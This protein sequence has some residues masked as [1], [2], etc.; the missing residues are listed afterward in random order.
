M[1]E[2]RAWT[3]AWTC[4]SCCAPSWSAFIDGDEEEEEEVEEVLWETGEADC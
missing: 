3:W 2:T 1:E 4:F